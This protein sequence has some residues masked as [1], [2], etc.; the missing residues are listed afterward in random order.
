MPF[1]S[2][3][4]RQKQD[5][6]RQS[7]FRLVVQSLNNQDYVWYAKSFTKPTAEI[8]SAQHR[9]L[10]HTFNY[11]GSVTWNTIDIELVDPTDPIDTAA[12]L[13]QLL[14]YMGY[15]IPSGPVDDMVNISK[16]KSVAALGDI[17]VEQ[18]NDLGETIE[19]WKLQQAYASK[20]DWG[21]YKYDSDDLNILKL[22]IT[23]DWATCEKPAIKDSAA[24]ETSP[25]VNAGESKQFWKDIREKRE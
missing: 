14:E 17:H 8:K 19:T 3:V 25:V 9:F 7:R 13:A 18:I 6:K 11:P 12:S 24:A 16:R 15:Q 4:D 5:P 2:A 10:N 1:W 20:I 22:T 23:Y 21:S